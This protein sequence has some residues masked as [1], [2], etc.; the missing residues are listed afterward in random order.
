M[1]LTD[2]VRIAELVAGAGVAAIAASGFELVRRQR[3][4]A[5]AIRPALAKRVWRV[6]VGAVV[7]VG[8]LTRA[9]FAQLVHPRPSRGLVVA[10]PFRHT[11]DDPDSRAHRAAAAALGSVA[12]N[13]I[14][15][16]VDQDAGL[17]VVHQLEATRKPSDL[18]PLGVR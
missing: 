12:P 2:S 11:A 10:I 1:V 5:Q 18:D 8:R 6:L 3:V 13:S 17:L 7:D 9:A 4:A 15:V 14:V 16:G